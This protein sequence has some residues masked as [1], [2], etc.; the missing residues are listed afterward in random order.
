LGFWI[1]FEFR[2]SNF[3]FDCA[4]QRNSDIV[5]QGAQ[6][7]MG[8]ALT[9]IAAGRTPKAEIDLIRERLKRLEEVVQ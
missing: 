1:C 5:T 4:T 2:I 8:R 9:I 7:E 3:A 6:I